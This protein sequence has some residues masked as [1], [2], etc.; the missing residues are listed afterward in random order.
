MDKTDKRAITAIKGIE[1]ESFVATSLNQMGWQLLHRATTAEGL[2]AALAAYPDATLI[3]TDDFLAQR[4]SSINPII[5]LKS[6][7]KLLE[8]EFQ[9]LLRRNHCEPT[10]IEQVLPL[11]HCEVTVLAGVDFG[12][13][14][15]TLAINLAHQS[16]LQGKS[17]LLLDCNIFNPYLARY[18]DIQRINRKITDT[19]FGFS[20]GEIGERSTFTEM[21][22][23]ADG[24]DEVFIDIGRLHLSEDL[25][26]EMNLH[27]ALVQWSLQ[28]AKRLY[29]LSRSDED[30]L[31]RLQSSFAELSR[32]S[33]PPATKAL[34][35]SPSSISG[36]TKKELIN[37]ASR[38]TEAQVVHLPRDP[39]GVGKALTQRSSLLIASPKSA[40]TV[41][42]GELYSAANQGPGRRQRESRR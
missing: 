27:P 22:Q 14:V 34:L 33:S 42:I 8:Y 17:T 23:A 24:F 2:S 4:T 1:L 10:S 3:T 30:S 13:G 7:D 26:S 6:R 29:L 36:R 15:S 41:E 40:L 19:P 16:A 32:H 25:L 12:L 35:T 28:S 37:R 18:F 38:L 21:A 31:I 20:I 11:T 9:E 39:I 5:T